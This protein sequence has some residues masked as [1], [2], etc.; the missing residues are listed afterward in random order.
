MKTTPLKKMAAL[1]LFVSIVLMIVAYNTVDASGDKITQS[2][3]MNNQTTGDVVGG[4]TLA[5]GLSGAD[6]DIRD[7]LATYSYLFGLVQR[8]RPNK[9]CVADQLQAVGKVYEAAQLRCSYFSIRRIYG[10][11]EE[12][13]SAL[14]HENYVPIVEAP[15]VIY[16]SDDEDDM[17]YELVQMELQHLKEQI[18]QAPPP[19]VV[20]QDDGAERRAKARAVLEEQ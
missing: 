3:D 13:V 4:K 14:I 12:C 2:N 17:E 1:Y 16:E 9:L 6:M 11:R 5:L 8:T 19:Q 7:C 20:I 15:V 18:Q 10:G